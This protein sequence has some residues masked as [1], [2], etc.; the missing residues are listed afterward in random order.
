MSEVHTI[1]KLYT[2]EVPYPKI[3]LKQRCD[4]KIPCSSCVRRGCRTICPLGSPTDTPRK[5]VNVLDTAALYRK[6]EEMG[7]RI[8]QLEDALSLLQASLSSSEPHPLLRDE[9][10]RIKFLPSSLEDTTDEK[11]GVPAEEPDLADLY[12][13]LTLEKGGRTR[14]L[15]RT[16]KP[17]SLLGVRASA[18]IYASKY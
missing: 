12:G 10:L 11:E 16:A 2:D 1:P 4:K 6:I 9:Y 3:R 17:E 18:P 7:Q 5:Q 14:Y 8:G 15:G 13:T